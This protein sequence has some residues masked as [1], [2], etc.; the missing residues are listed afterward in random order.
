MVFCFLCSTRPV[1][2]D[3]KAKKNLIESNPVETNNR[4]KQRRHQMRLTTSILPV[5]T[6]SLIF[7]GNLSPLQADV[8]ESANPVIQDKKNLER[9]MEEGQAQPTLDLPV[10]LPVVRDE[11]SE[12]QKQLLNRLNAA[13]TQKEELKERFAVV[14]GDWR[15]YDN[16]NTGWVA[17]WVFS[18]TIGGAGVFAG[19]LSS[20]LSAATIGAIALSGPILLLVGGALLGASWGFY[21]AAQKA[22][23]NREKVQNGEYQLYREQD[24]NEAKIYD[25]KQRLGLDSN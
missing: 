7:L 5:L 16:Q 6:L 19:A 21:S 14:H 20:F 3:I 13:R 8:T 23:D 24:I 22:K 9:L 4:I 12:T 15:S 2:K 17:A 18:L 10:K 25:L 11:L 1:R